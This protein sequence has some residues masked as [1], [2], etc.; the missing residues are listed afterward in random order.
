MMNLTKTRTPVGLPAAAPGGR[1]EVGA[2]PAAVV[3][4]RR[5]ALLLADNCNITVNRN[6]INFV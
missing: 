5:V 4:D 3:G 1:P 6:M 2:G